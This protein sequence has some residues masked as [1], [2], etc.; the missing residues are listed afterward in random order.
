MAPLPRRLVIK[1][2]ASAQDGRERTRRR[3]RAGWCRE[4]RRRPAHFFVFCFFVHVRNVRVP[5]RLNQVG[6]SAFMIQLRSSC[7]KKKKKNTQT[8]AVLLCSVL[9][10]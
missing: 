6:V 4:S 5:S 8:W 2:T 1:R 7:L 3:F 9:A 10:C